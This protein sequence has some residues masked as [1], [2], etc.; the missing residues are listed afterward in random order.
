MEK[1]DLSV[2]QPNIP[3]M[4]WDVDK[5]YEIIALLTPKTLSKLSTL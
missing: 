3:K 5:C 1:I 4:Q 2:D